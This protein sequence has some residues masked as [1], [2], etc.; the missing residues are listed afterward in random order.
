LAKIIGSSNV[1]VRILS[2]PGHHECKLCVTDLWRAA[3]R[4]LPAEEFGPGRRFWGNFVRQRWAT[5]PKT[6]RF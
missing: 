6:L 3:A 4:N 2:V 5:C 1:K